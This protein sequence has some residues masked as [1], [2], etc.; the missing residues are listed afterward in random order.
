M[1]SIFH[2][3][4]NRDT[5][6]PPIIWQPGEKDRQAVCQPARVNYLLGLNSAEH[7]KPYRHTAPQY[8]VEVCVRICEDEGKT[9]EAN[10][11]LKIFSISINKSFCRPPL[12][13]FFFCS[14]YW[15]SW[16]VLSYSSIML[17]IQTELA[18]PLLLHQGP[19]R[20][21]YESSLNS[22][23]TAERRGRWEKRWASVMWFSTFF[24]WVSS[25]ASWGPPPGSLVSSMGM[26]TEPCSRDL[27]AIL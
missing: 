7:S 15:S 17:S 11:K 27:S 18:V 26:L 25:G 24:K 12:N 6:A 5:L 3:R 23:S 10:T 14:T 9:R 2:E 20:M 1:P 21:V 4:I 19:S 13:F 22:R 16:V 8:K